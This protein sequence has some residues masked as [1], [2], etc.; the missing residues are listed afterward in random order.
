LKRTRKGKKALGKGRVK[1]QSSKV[2]GQTGLRQLFNKK[3]G[4]DPK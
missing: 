4:G 1:E 2:V 3:K